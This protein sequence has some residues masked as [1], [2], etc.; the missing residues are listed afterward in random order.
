MNTQWLERLLLIFGSLVLLGFAASYAIEDL[1]AYREAFRI[2][3]I[4]GIA[5]YAIY[6]FLVQSKDQK[7]IHS[8]EVEAE[9]F[10]QLAKKERQRGDQLQE[11][12]LDLQNSLAEAQKEAEE[13]KAKM[14][15]LESQKD[16]QE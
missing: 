2:A 10:H 14:A 8:A 7:Q 13:L 12:N 4:V 6:S 11:A 16:Q 5:L 1:K 3:A 15:E 9:N